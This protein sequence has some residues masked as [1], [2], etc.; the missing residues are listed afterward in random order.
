VPH[1]QVNAL[2]V[3]A[4]RVI[5]LRVN[6]LRLGWGFCNLFPYLRNILTPGIL[7]MRLIIISLQRGVVR[8][9]PM[10]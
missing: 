2:R 7:W 1:L 5:A 4:L 9:C 10:I 8:F 6:A 3:I